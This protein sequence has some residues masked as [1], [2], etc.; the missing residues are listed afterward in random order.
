MS[1]D[2]NIKYKAF[3]C[4]GRD[5]EYADVHLNIT[6]NLGR[7]ASELGVYEMLW[8]NDGTKKCSEQI[9]QLIE[10][11]DKLSSNIEYYHQFNS[12]N[13]W[14]TA[15]NFEDFLGQVIYEMKLNP[16]AYIES[17]A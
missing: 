2:V 15:D 16:N 11:K 5:E 10:A 1:L 3:E 14:G 13:G 17:H 6:H 9:D 12:S 4:C 8:K 7:I